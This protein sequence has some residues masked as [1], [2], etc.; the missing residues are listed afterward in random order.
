MRIGVV[1]ATLGRPGLV[2]LMI[3]RLARQTRLADRIVVSATGPADLPAG[4]GPGEHGPVLV[5]VG[6]A[7]ACVQRNRAV[8]ALTEADCWDRGDVIVF[9]DDDFVPALNWLAEAEAFGRSHPEVAGF[10]GVVLADGAPL[11]GYDV[12]E[13]ERILA[14]GRPVLPAGDWRLVTGSVGALYGCNMVLRADLAIA[15][16]FDEAL[17]LYAWLED[18]D[19][20]VRLAQHGALVRPATLTGVHLG[21]KSGRSSGRRLGYSQVANAFHLRGKRTLSTRDMVTLIGKNLAANLRGSLRPE[22]FIDRRGRLTGNLRALFDLARG[23]LSPGN[24]AR[25]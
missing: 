17:P 7:G 14:T 18:R 3:E 8:A 22:P 13:A 11:A 10:T 2:G 16:P 20:S 25:L 15:T 23:Q 5:V 19:V 21:T 9:L 1:V 6:P 24:A 4:L 12:A